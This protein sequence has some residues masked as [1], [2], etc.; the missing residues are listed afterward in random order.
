MFTLKIVSFTICPQ[1]VASNYIH[2]YILCTVWQILAQC[3]RSVLDTNNSC[4]FYTKNSLKYFANLQQVLFPAPAIGFHTTPQTG[5]SSQQPSHS[6]TS[7][8]AYAMKLAHWAHRPT[9]RKTPLTQCRALSSNRDLAVL[10][11]QVAVEREWRGFT[12]S[13]SWWPLWP[14]RII[15]TSPAANNAPVRRVTFST[16]FSLLS[17]EN[18]RSGQS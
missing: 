3:K 13:R 15:Q 11:K 6:S 14:V 7:L 16:N 10:W 17:L 9:T 12:V 1:S 8:L 4:L 18:N 5:V 2:I